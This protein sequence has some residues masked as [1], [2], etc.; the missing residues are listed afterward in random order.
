M[1]NNISSVKHAI[2][3]VPS[4]ADVVVPQQKGFKKQFQ[5]TYFSMP[6]NNT[7]KN[8]CTLKLADVGGLHGDE[9]GPPQGST[10]MSGGFTSK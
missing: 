10:Q 5:M 1:P 9:D 3:S 4:L 8:I 6:S 2:K 7:S